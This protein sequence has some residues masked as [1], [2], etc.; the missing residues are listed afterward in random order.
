MMQKG[1]THPRHW[2]Y[3]SFPLC[4]QRWW[5]HRYTCLSPAPGHYQSRINNQ[6]EMHWMLASAVRELCTTELYES[7]LQ[8]LQL[9]VPSADSYHMK[10]WD[11]ASWIAGGHLCARTGWGEG[12]HRSGSEAPLDVLAS[13]WH[14][15]P[16]LWC[17]AA[18]W[19]TRR[20]PADYINMLTK[21]HSEGC[22]QTVSTLNFTQ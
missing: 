13:L 7:A 20:R 15:P 19:W 18:L 14:S 2:G 6:R 11:R 21:W 4:L 8:F 5:L 3:S 10:R 16:R 22:V 17:W 12:W 9:A 1:P